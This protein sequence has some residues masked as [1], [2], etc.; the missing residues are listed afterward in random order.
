MSYFI[1]KV[2]PA[3]SVDPAFTIV[4]DGTKE[5]TNKNYNLIY[6]F[7]I[8]MMAEKSSLPKEKHRRACVEI[9]CPSSGLKEVSIFVKKS[10]INYFY[11]SHYHNPYCHNC[12]IL[13]M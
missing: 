3:L 1:A 11:N 10:Y 7:V 5:S 6:K 2:L 12:F 9:F 4:V 8:L 13:I